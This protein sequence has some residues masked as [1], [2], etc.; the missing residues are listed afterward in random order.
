MWLLTTFKHFGKS[1]QGYL[2]SR[3]EALFSQQSTNRN[4]QKTP[5]YRVYVRHLG[6]AINYPE[7]PWSGNE[8]WEQLLG[9]GGWK[10]LTGHAELLEKGSCF[11][12]VILTTIHD[13]SNWSKFQNVYLLFLAL[14][15]EGG[16]G[17]QCDLALF[18][19][20]EGR[21]A[22]WPYN[23]CFRPPKGLYGVNSK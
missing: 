15:L 2:G 5:V 20:E 6:S 11:E 4:L 23:N 22:V 12:C 16:G 7:S 1:L 19:K 18:W 17:G 14:F 3:C 8:C 21:G 9:R 10:R 13:Q